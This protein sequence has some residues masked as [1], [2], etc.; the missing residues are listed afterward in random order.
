MKNKLF[1]SLKSDICYRTGTS[2]FSNFT[3]SLHSKSQRLTEQLKNNPHLL[4]AMMD[5]LRGN[6]GDELE[7]RGISRVSNQDDILI[8]PIK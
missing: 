8:Q 6:L 3:G 4:E 7:K 5:E 2:A 1:S